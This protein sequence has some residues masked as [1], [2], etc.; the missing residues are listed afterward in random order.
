MHAEGE[1]RNNLDDS[2]KVRELQDKVAELKAEVCRVKKFILP[3]LTNAVSRNI[4]VRGELDVVTIKNTFASCNIMYVK[5]LYKFNLN[6]ISN[7]KNIL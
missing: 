5:R 6:V 7:Y 3:V 2:E 1:L 4:A